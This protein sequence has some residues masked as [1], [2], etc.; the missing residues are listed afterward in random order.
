MLL[1]FIFSFGAAGPRYRQ[2]ARGVRGEVVGCRASAWDP[3]TAQVPCELLPPQFTQCVTHSF[4]KFRDEFEGGALPEM[5]CRRGRRNEGLFGAAVCHPLAGIRCVGE[6]Y[7]VNASYPCY[8]SGEYSVGKAVVLSFFLGFFGADRFYLGHYFLGFLKLF[9]GGG[10]LVWWA[11]DF[12]L[13]AAG[14]WGPVSGG[15]SLD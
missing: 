15:Y 12:L 14:V 2:C 6:R 4:A 7:W 13:L 9:T 11:A 5:G 1:S 10:L 8:E 3:A